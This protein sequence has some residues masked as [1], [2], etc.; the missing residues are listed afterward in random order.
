MTVTIKMELSTASG[1]P[2]AELHMLPAVVF[3]TKLSSTS[4]SAQV[5]YP[6]ASVEL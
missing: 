5:S 1:D 4:W 6:S 3:G 2:V